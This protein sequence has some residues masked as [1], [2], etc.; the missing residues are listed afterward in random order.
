VANEALSEAGE[1]KPHVKTYTGFLQVTKI[2]IVLT[3][4][5]AIAVILIIA[6]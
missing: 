4:I 6:R 5:V 2:G 3:A 1:M